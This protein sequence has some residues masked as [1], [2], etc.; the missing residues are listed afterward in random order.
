MNTPRKKND[1]PPKPIWGWGNIKGRIVCKEFFRVVEANLLHIDSRTG[2]DKIQSEQPFKD[3]LGK[4]S[5]GYVTGSGFMEEFD[6]ELAT[7][8]LYILHRVFH[9]T[10]TS[11]KTDVGVRM[12]P[13]PDRPT[14]GKAYTYKSEFDVS[15]NATS[16]EKARAYV[17]RT[18][19]TS[20]HC[21]WFLHSPVAVALFTALFQAAGM[22][23][24]E[25]R[26]SLGAEVVRK[27][28]DAPN[29]WREDMESHHRVLISIADNTQEAMQDAVYKAFKNK[30]DDVAGLY[31]TP[32]MSDMPEPPKGRK[33]KMLTLKYVG[34]F[35]D[36]LKMFT[37]KSYAGRGLLALVIY[38]EGLPLIFPNR[39]PIQRILNGPA[40]RWVAAPILRALTGSDDSFRQETFSAAM[41]DGWKVIAGSDTTVGRFVRFVNESYNVGIAVSEQGRMVYG[42]VENAT[43]KALEMG[44]N[45]FSLGVE[46]VHSSID[47][48][49]GLGSLLNNTM[50]ANPHPIVP[51]LAMNATAA[52]IIAQ[53]TNF[54]HSNVQEMIEREKLAELQNRPATRQRR[55]VVNNAITRAIERGD[56][57]ALMEFLKENYHEMW[58]Q[59]R[60]DLLSQP[61][62]NARLPAGQ[63]PSMPPSLPG[64]PSFPN[65]PSLNRLN[66]VGETVS[67]SAV[68]KD[69]EARLDLVAPRPLL[70]ATTTIR[71]HARESTT[72]PRLFCLPEANF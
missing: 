42:N 48:I 24:F 5:L 58:E 52:G 45:A 43:N 66:F 1:Q 26:S 2:W 4:T 23:G 3:V 14:S 33:G 18:I 71:Y 6:G 60:T 49:R 28:L 51:T 68:T 11:T 32:D 16:R 13:I 29:K 8:M 59:S 27:A 64:R 47:T 50:A 10:G 57:A 17:Y 41:G 19:Y 55:D 46:G 62:V 56:Q 38:H 15:A 70:S 69:L 35:G 63:V 22:D 21:S 25:T 67:V 30:H 9:G 31:N 44:A 54:N 39:P 61:G 40:F 37:P 12:P 34:Y 65:F 36:F 7:E 20:L 53:S 72:T